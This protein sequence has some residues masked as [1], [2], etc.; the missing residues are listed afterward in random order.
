M[1][2][3]IVQI[4]SIII[5]VLFTCVVLTSC[6][7]PASILSEYSISDDVTIDSAKTKISNQSTTDTTSLDPGEKVTF[8]DKEF[9]RM[10]KKI[11]NKENSDVYLEHLKN[12]KEIYIFGETVNKVVNEGYVEENEE[13]DD[14]YYQYEDDKGNKFTEKGKIKSIEDLRYFKGLEKLTIIHQEIES[15]EVLEQLTKLKYID[16][17]DNKVRKI[18]SLRN[19]NNLEYADFTENGISDFSPVSKLQ[20]LKYLNLS[21]NGISNILSTISENLSIEALSLNNNRIVNFSVIKGMKNLKDLDISY[22]NPKRD[23][24]ND[25]AIDI[26]ALKEL[27]NLQELNLSGNVKLDL[28]VVGELKSLLKLSMNDCYISDI[29]DLKI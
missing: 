19:L 24:E 23:T 11:T 1:K 9:E 4:C 21:Q 6:G 2:K 5:L 26:S 17:R 20:K 25:S 12:I 27:K 3:I 22:N 8:I 28:S 18:E 15:V 10:V 16:L 7:S 14:S 29:S 13:S